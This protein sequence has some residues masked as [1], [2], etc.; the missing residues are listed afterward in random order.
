MEE[1]PETQ[2]QA[3][4]SKD[5]RAMVPLPGEFKTPEGFRELLKSKFHF[6]S[7]GMVF[8]INALK[9]R[10]GVADLL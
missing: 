8:G 7:P 9:S 2:D 1:K 4:A 10:D 5:G 6:F 3:E